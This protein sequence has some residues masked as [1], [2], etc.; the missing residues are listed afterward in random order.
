MDVK[1]RQKSLGRPP[2]GTRVDARRQQAALISPERERER[3]GVN[4]LLLPQA[5]EPMSDLLVSLF[6]NGVVHRDLKLE[7]VLLDENCNIKVTG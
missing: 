5:R 1:C 6:Q 2:E 7:N 4:R 3:D